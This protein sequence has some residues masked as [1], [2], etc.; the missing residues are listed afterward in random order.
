MKSTGSRNFQLGLF[1]IISTVILIVAIYLIG[2]KKDIFSNTFNLKVKFGNVNGLQPGNNVRLSG[3]NVGSVLAVEIQNDS[4]VEVTIRVREEVRPHIK[5]NSVATIGTDGLMGNMLINISPGKGESEIVKDDDYLQTYSRIKTDDILKT[6]TTTNEN[7]A[8]LT[9]ELLEIVHEIRQGKG[10]IS[11]LLYDTSLREEIYLTARNLRTSTAKTNAFLSELNEITNS[12]NNGR[13]LAGWLINDTITQQKVKIM[14][15]R[16]SFSSQKIQ[17]STDSLNQLIV[18]L[19]SG[20]G[21]IPAIM[22]DTAMVSDLRQTL[23]NLN[24]GTGKFNENMK[25]LESHFLFRKYFKDKE[26]NKK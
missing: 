8:L 14:M 23:E 5:K 18:S 10:T 17:T 24:V 12:V 15:N 21:I 25:A 4:I 9:S 3:I 6:L 19:S 20:E 16:L 13:G 1:T 26:K 7:A 22:K 11:F 2:Q